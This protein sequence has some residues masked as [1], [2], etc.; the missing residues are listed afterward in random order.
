MR[1]TADTAT[2]TWINGYAGR[3]ANLGAACDMPETT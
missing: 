3:G 2:L 1:V